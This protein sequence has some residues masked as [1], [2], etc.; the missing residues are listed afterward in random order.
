[1]KSVH[2]IGALE[3]KGGRC[4]GGL[5]STPP[6]DQQIDAGNQTQIYIK[7]LCRD[8]PYTPCSTPPSYKKF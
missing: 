5:H 1:M 8:C 7:R 3:E 4:R 6:R 2:G